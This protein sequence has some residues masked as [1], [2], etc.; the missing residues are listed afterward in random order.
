[1]K[2]RTIAVIDGFSLIKVKFK[3]T[4]NHFNVYDSVT[5]S[6][7]GICVTTTAL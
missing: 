7:V 2:V 4:I 6:T 5:F 3:H 1:M